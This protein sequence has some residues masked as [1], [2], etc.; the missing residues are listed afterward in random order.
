MGPE[1][2]GGVAGAAAARLWHLQE[3]RGQL[4]APRTRARGAGALHVV[5]DGASFAVALEAA[6]GAGAARARWPGGV[7]VLLPRRADVALRRAVFGPLQCRLAGRLA[8]REWDDS[9]GEGPA[10]A[11]D[12]SGALEGGGTAIVMVAR[13]ALVCWV[14]RLVGA[15]P[16]LDKVVVVIG[17]EAGAAAQP[18]L[19]LREAVRLLD[20]S[21][22]DFSIVHAHRLVSGPATGAVQC[23]LAEPSAAACGASEAEPRAVTVGDLAVLLLECACPRSPAAGT[24]RREWERLCA[25]PRV[26]LRCCTYGEREQD[27]GY[28]PGGAALSR[29]REHHLTVRPKLPRIPDRYSG[30][31]LTAPVS[32]WAGLKFAKA[33]PACVSTKL[34][35]GHELRVRPDDMASDR[36]NLDPKDLRRLNHW[37]NKSFGN[38][39]VKAAARLAPSS[40]ADPARTAPEAPAIE[41]DSQAP[42]SKE[43]H[44]A[45]QDASAAYIAAVH[46][47][48]APPPFEPT[49]VEGE[50]LDLAIAQAASLVVMDFDDGAAND[51]P[52]V[53]LASSEAGEQHKANVV[54]SDEA[55]AAEGEDDEDEDEEEDTRASSAL[56]L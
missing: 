20:E 10:R 8:L 2:Q 12:S 47:A 29:H 39:N 41:P 23:K 15:V 37:E 6:G 22:L 50:G 51:A 28:G 13:G 3:Q 11:P 43:Q 55:S 35:P 56:R 30:P 14:R 40:A 17:S 1:L 24:P 45:T 42:E 54:V 4:A 44:A 25:L 48:A 16:R 27:W 49:T 5:A 9:G 36:G 7:A 26:A 52:G 34:R 31:I 38:Y 18:A 33:R 46:A 32:R 19:E 21:C 53:Q